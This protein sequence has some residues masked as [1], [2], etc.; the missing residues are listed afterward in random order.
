MPRSTSARYGDHGTS[1]GGFRRRQPLLTTSS[2]VATDSTISLSSGAGL[3]TPGGFVKPQ[4][5]GPEI[6]CATG[7]TLGPSIS[8]EDPAFLYFSSSCRKDGAGGMDIY[9]APMPAYDWS[10]ER[11]VQQ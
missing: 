11:N 3:G 1:T 9:R 5:I 6:N 2:A 4:L 10:R 8:R 7:L